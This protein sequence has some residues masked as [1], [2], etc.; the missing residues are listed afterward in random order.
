L[1]LNRT[2]RKK[3]SPFFDIFLSSSILAGYSN[4]LEM[5]G[6]YFHI[7]GK[8]GVMVFTGRISLKTKG[9]SHILD[10]TIFS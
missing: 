7:D 9:F 5:V 3:G 10:I 4:F 2:G 8:G 1:N 6:K